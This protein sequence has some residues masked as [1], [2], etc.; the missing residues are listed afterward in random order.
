MFLLWCSLVIIRQLRQKELCCGSDSGGTM[1][2]DWP[3]GFGV[4]FGG[5]S[6][7]AALLARSIWCLVLLVQRCIRSI[8][9]PFVSI[10][11][12]PAHGVRRLLPLCRSKKR[13]SR[14]VNQ[15][16]VYFLCRSLL[17]LPLLF[18]SIRNG[19]EAG[20]NMLLANA[21]V[22]SLKV[23]P[24]TTQMSYGSIFNPVWS[25]TVACRLLSCLFF[26]LFTIYQWSSLLHRHVRSVF[27]SI[28]R[29]QGPLK[30]GCS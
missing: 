4:W 1:W 21:P 20:G 18:N 8:T 28:D 23:I 26:V 27:C 11:A 13:H 3:F 12:C 14:K 2:P 17:C 25:S 5:G 7:E 6:V 29:V 19:K 22:N 15:H 9:R 30:L 24:R 10:S 16:I